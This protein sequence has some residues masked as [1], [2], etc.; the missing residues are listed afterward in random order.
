LLILGGGPIGCE[1]AQAFV[2][3]GAKVTLVEKEH[4]LLKREDA[5]GAQ[6]IAE[7]LQSEGV[8]LRLESSVIEC[9]RVSDEESHVR[10][11][12]GGRQ[13]N[14]VVDA[15]LV[16]I[17]KVANVSDLDL[18]R[19]GVECSEKGV[20]VDDYLRTTNKSIYA[21]G[22]VCSATMFTHSADFQSRLVLRNALFSLG[23][24]GRR[25]VSQLLIPRV[26]YTA[27]EFA[28]VGLSEH[29]AKVRGTEVNVFRKELRE[30]DRSI[31]EGEE[32]GFFKVIVKKGT[33]TILGATI[34]SPYA[35]EHISQL[36]QAIQ[37][38]I[39][40]GQ[41]ADTMFPYPTRAD[42]IRRLGDEYNRTRLTTFS[43]KIL[44][45]L[46]KWNT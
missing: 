27:P 38:G 18:G 28:Q 37:H 7:Q 36:T 43:L 26:V 13:E 39:G 16:A 22:D 34:I 6:I 8:D 24:L 5:E 2:R 23:P 3:L 46:L 1:M 14:V 40:L 35:G 21:S 44:R 17:G 4:S 30:N 9:Q 41:I 31:I 19:A 20:V 25:K 15:I 42:L 11:E 32:R 33:D 29:E 45:G 12:S 10:V